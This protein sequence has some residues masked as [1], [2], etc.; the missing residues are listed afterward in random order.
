MAA[1][2]AVAK[3]LGVGIHRC[4]SPALVA[5][6]TLLATTADW[7]RALAADGVAQR[8]RVHGEP[9]LPLTHS[10]GAAA[11]RPHRPQ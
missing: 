8:W 10:L 5:E 4:T 6:E 11:A 1:A 2:E 3:A 7:G 9:A